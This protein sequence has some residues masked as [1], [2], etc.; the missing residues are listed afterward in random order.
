MILLWVSVSVWTSPLRGQFSEL[1]T[2][3]PQIN[4]RNFGAVDDAQVAGGC[5]VTSGTTV[6]CGNVFTAADVGKAIE[7]P[8]A[9]ISQSAPLPG[10]ATFE[11]TISTIGTGSCNTSGLC[12]TVILA[13]PTSNNPTNQTVTW[14]TNNDGAFQAALNACPAPSNGATTAVL[15]GF[16]SKGCVLL[17]PNSG[18]AGTGDYL[19]VNGVVA[20]IQTSFQDRRDGKF[21]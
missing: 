2:P 20:S 1:T 10:H 4:V 5:S 18:G 15:Q 14:G 17:V 11:T 8:N 16:T 7:I 3:L 19:F 6:T 9:G 21:G 13:A 12:T